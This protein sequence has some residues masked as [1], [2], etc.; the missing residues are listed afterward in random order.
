MSFTGSA[1][2]VVARL[3]KLLTPSGAIAAL[4][5]SAT[6]VDT[7]GLVQPNGYGITMSHNDSGVGDSA[8]V[9]SYS[10]PANVNNGVEGV[11]LLGPLGVGHSAQPGMALTTTRFGLSH[12]GSAELT[13]GKYQAA[14]TQAL[15]VIQFNGN[16]SSILE[17]ATQKVITVSQS[18]VGP[19]ITARQFRY[20][21]ADA[22][23]LA[24]A[25]VNPVPFGGGAGA[26]IPGTAIT[27]NVVIG[28]IIKVEASYD[29]TNT[30]VGNQFVGYARF[31][32]AV[33]A[34]INALFQTAVGA[35]VQRST[36]P[37][38]LQVVAAATGNLVVELWCVENVGVSN[39]ATAGMHV[40]VTTAS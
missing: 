13:P 17:V 5:G 19:A 12:Q 36:V 8:L 18:F 34:G 1:S 30:G 40:T 27:L 25:P 35:T 14:D 2:T 11:E 6:F 28:D 10:E 37:A 21:V 39:L 16:S 3:F 29:V 31:N 4:F 24:S 38:H 15:Y 9:W 7:G 22:Y 33:M 32:G 23:S 26:A 20:L